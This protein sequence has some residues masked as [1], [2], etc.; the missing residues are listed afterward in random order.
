VQP[1]ALLHEGARRLG[2]AW[3]AYLA[4]LDDPRAGVRRSAGGSDDRGVGSTRDGKLAA[5]R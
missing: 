4:S 3:Q 1:V 5:T 2:D